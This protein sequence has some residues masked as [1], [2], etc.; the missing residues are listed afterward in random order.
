MSVG[1]LRIEKLLNALKAKGRSSP[2]GIYWQRF[3]ERLKAMEKN[4]GNGPPV[5]LILATSDESAGSKQRRLSS[6]LEWALKNDS[7]DDAIRYLEDIPKD[8][9]NTC[10]AESW[11]QDSYM[12]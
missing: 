2:D 6:Q 8:K 4:S 5:P 12:S 7:L 1:N 11:E 9:W 3:Y 10:S